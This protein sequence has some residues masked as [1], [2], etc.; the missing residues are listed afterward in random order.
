[1]QMALPALSELRASVPRARMFQVSTAMSQLL[2]ISSGAIACVVLTI[3]GPFVSWWVGPDRFA[4]PAL[5]GLLVLG[6]LLRHWNVAAVYTLFCFGHERRL[7][8]TT[9]VDGLVGLVAMLLLV[10]WL[11]MHGA[12]LGSLIGTA[13]ISLPGNLRALAREEGVSLAAAIRPLRPWFGRFVLVSATVLFAIAWWPDQ[14]LRSG[15]RWIAG[16]DPLRRAHA[17]RRA[18]A[19]AGL[20]ARPSAAAMAHPLSRPVE[21]SRQPVHAV[22]ATSADTAGTA[23][24]LHA[25]PSPAPAARTHSGLVEASRKPVDSVMMT[26]PQAE[27]PIAGHAVN[28]LRAVRTVRSRTSIDTSSASTGLRLRYDPGRERRC[29]RGRQARRPPRP[30][31]KALA[32]P[33]QSVRVGRH[34]GRPRT[35]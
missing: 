22:M 6:M 2:L 14:R 11:G 35:P 30:Q 7:A 19:A 5:T 18:E 26:S 29:G 23:A 16:G 15:D 33:R 17:A 12:A 25:G 31:S 28:R 27:L 4:G 3:N 20:D 32:L 9:A 1:M 10:P 8:I 24:G 21:T 13:G 34:A